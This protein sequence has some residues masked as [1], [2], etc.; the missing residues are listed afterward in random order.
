M[1][2]IAGISIFITFI[3]L[4]LFLLFSSGFSLAQDRVR[5]LSGEKERELVVGRAITVNT[6]Y[7]IGDV[8]VTDQS[9]VDYIV[10]RNRMEIYLNPL[11]EGKA[12]LTIWDNRSKVQEVYS[13]KVVSVKIDSLLREVKSALGHISGI[14]IDLI[15]NQNI[16]IIGEVSSSADLNLIK[17]Y[18]EKYPQIKA[19]VSLS[20][21][22]LSITADQ[23]KSAIDIPGIDVRAVRGNL[24]MEGL[25]YSKDAY[26]KIDT[27]ARLYK[28]DIINLVEMRQSNRR[29]GYDKSVK[30]DVYFMEVK[31]SAIRS[32]GINWAPGSTP[33]SAAANIG[34]GGV[35][36]G[37][38]FIDIPA[39]FGF[40]VNLLPK[41]RWIHETNRGR[42]LEKA[43]FVVKS[44]ESVNFYSGTQIPYFNATSVTFKEVGIRIK[45]EPIV[46][47]SDVDLN[48]NVTVSSPSSRVSQG[49]DTNEVS[50]TVYVKSGE[51][52]VLGDLLRNND[53]KTYNKVPPNVDPSSA[54]FSLFLS[55]DFQTNKSQFYIFILPTTVEK[56]TTAES[57][58]KRWLELNDAVNEARR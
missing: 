27:I 57:E 23:I 21:R 44:G 50:T 4:F 28:N 36:Q 43:G 55:R 1:R 38:S 15:G 13:L 48:I 42:V 34:G 30:L 45:A 24:V 35:S 8:A 19:K 31:N 49:V 10:Q 32:F 54:I 16:R 22:A 53:V 11:K 47:D 14:R 6:D 9:V 58:L 29:P 26:K 51:A 33:S 40:I 37:M 7:T 17:K 56:M 20:S 39:I 2:K 25:T 18:E 41:I 12:T 46:H 52:V 5:K 3:S